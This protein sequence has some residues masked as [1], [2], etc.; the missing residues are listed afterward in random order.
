MGATRDV[1]RDAALDKLPEAAD[2]ET[3]RALLQPHFGAG[4]Q[5]LRVKIGRFTY[6]PGQSARLCYH[7]K[8]RDLASGAKVRHVVHGRMELP[9]HLA[10][11]HAR[12]RGKTWV[13]PRYGPALLHL[14]ELS[15]LLWGFPNDPKLRGLERVAEPDQLL[16][17]ARR[18][19]ALGALEPAACTSEVVKY[20]PGKRLVMRH[21]LRAGNGRSPV[22]LYG[23][24][25]GHERGRAIFEVI[26]HLWKLGEGSD[27]EEA[28]GAASALVVPEPLAYIDKMH[29]LLLR[30]LPGET[31]VATLQS[32]AALRRSMSQAGRGLCRIHTSGVAGLEPW[33]EAHEFENFLR[34]TALLQ[35]Y[36]ADLA[37]PIERLRARGEQAL[38]GVERQ[39][40]VPIHGAFRFTQLLSY[41]ERLALVD[42]DGFRQG[43]PMCDVGSFVAHLLY[44]LAK[45]ELQESEARE[46]ASVF[47]QAYAADSPW[48]IPDRAFEWYTATILV[49]KHALKCV[50]RLKDDGD[51]KIRRMLGLA[52][53]ILARRLTLG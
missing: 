50:K 40:G 45:G 12:M 44:L 8:L 2:P 38:A 13:Q 53:D 48:G 30:G 29:T 14:P 43:H 11:L 18:L 39:D 33:S 21:E 7:L 41:G 31:A 46:A 6:K 15:M 24:T 52:E 25:Y 5:L 4:V 17:I 47:L 16:G 37:A 3:V 27:G 35:R 19:P 20:V 22:I 42:F 51:A 23:K 28:G 36:D 49:A 32:G 10:A 26:H 34:A 1:P 9:E